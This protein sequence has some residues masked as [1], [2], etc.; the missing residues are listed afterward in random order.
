M[1]KVLIT[2]GNGDIAKAIASVL[3]SKG[4]YDVKCP[5]R[6]DLDVTNPTAVEKFMDAFRPDIL[7]NNAGYI[8][9]AGLKENDWESDIRTINVNLSGVFLCS[10]FALKYNPDVC[11]I[12][13]GSSAGTKNR[14]DWS[15]YCATKSAVISA[16]DCWAQEGVKAVCISPGR[17]KTKMRKGMF[18]DEDQSTL[19]TPEDF[20]Q[21]VFQAVTGKFSWGANI[22]VNVNNVKEFL[23]D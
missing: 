14:G 9:I 5:G 17:A 11:I 2:G 7:I 12:N 4:E 8:K 1:K 23:N 15:S 3:L 13:I 16:T 20:A 10:S 6:F 21:V 19:M 22:N 18:P